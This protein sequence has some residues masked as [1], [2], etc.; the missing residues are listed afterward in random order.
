VSSA[1]LHTELVTLLDAAARDEY[2]YLS[3]V[4]TSLR[5]CHEEAQR[6]LAEVDE[7]SASS[8]L[9]DNRPLNGHATDKHRQPN[10]HSKSES[11][12]RDNDLESAL[13]FRLTSTTFNSSKVQ[14]IATQLQSLHG[15][16]TALAHAKTV[17]MDAVFKVSR[18]QIDMI[19]NEVDAGEPESDT[20]D[21][22]AAVALLSAQPVALGE[23]T[24]HFVQMRDLL[25]NH[26]FFR[27]ESVQQHLQ[28]VTH[29]WAT[30][31]T[32]GNICLAENALN[33]LVGTG[34]LSY[35]IFVAVTMSLFRRMR[36]QR[37]CAR[38]EDR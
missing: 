22:M 9:N 25:Q 26:E 7:G 4:S 12:R 36:K 5:L 10:G 1:D 35:R 18:M 15:Q 33:E 6:Y 31:F 38:C 20:Q 13:Y 27:T 21:S 37:A 17:A 3:Q 34:A 32:G 8:A 2:T 11:K 29:L 28:T 23:R 30:M 16:M 19:S 24:R 14:A